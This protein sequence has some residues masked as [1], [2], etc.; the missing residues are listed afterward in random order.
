M[1]H[2]PP[3][4][5]LMEA[6]NFGAADLRENRNGYLSAAQVAVLR[7]R[8]QTYVATGTVMVFAT[9]TIFVLIYVDLLM[10][11]A[12]DA[13]HEQMTI[14][15]LPVSVIVLLS[16]MALVTRPWRQT[17]ADI[18]E[19]RV[20]SVNGKVRLDAWANLHHIGVGEI[21]FRVEPPVFA[22]FKDGESYVIYFI[23]RAKV[24]VAAEPA[25]GVPEDR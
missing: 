7:Q 22:A 21:K 3:E 23:P 14:V 16:V 20:Y 24:I 11:G 8:M 10:R 1:A 19:G 6:L 18:E 15:L 17:R 2:R 9:I 12:S 5:A 13:R 25:P 4:L